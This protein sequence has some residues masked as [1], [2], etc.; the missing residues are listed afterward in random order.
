MKRFAGRFSKPVLPGQ[1]LKTTFWNAGER[2]GVK[3]FAFETETS[4]GAVIKDGVV[5]IS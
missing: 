5:E 2:D 1:T 3:V 4:E